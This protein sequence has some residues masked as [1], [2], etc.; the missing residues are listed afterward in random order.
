MKVLNAMAIV[1]VVATAGSLMASSANAQ[2]PT[3]AALAIP[4]WCSDVPASPAPPGF[5]LRAGNWAYVRK[6]CSSETSLN[7]RT[8]ADICMDARARWKMKKSGHLSK[9]QSI[10]STDKLPRSLSASRRCERIYSAGAT[11]TH[12][13]RSDVRCLRRL[14][15]SL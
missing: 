12:S 2:Q 8:C 7:F 3:P 11:A 1:I 10:R 14:R 5:E 9:S 15:S 6:A 4:N 13:Q